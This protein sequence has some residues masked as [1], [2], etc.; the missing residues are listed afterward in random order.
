MTGICPGR[1]CPLIGLV[2]LV[3]TRKPAWT[4]SVLPVDQVGRDGRDP[5]ARFDKLSDRTRAVSRGSAS[6][7]LVEFV[8]SLGQR[9][10]RL[11]GLS[12]TFRCDVQC[13]PLRSIAEAT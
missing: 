4:S 1:P 13:A 11:V 7:G 2:E 9:F 10:D 8:Q 12:V 6:A 5:Q 3:E